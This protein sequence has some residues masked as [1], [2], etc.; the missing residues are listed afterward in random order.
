MSKPFEGFKSISA[1]ARSMGISLQTLRYRI[2]KGL[3]ART[4]RQTFNHLAESAGLNPSTVRSRLAR[5]LSLEEALSRPLPVKKNPEERRERDRPARR[6]WIERNRERRR[7]SDRKRRATPR[8]QARVKAWRERRK[9]LLEVAK[10]AGLIA[11]FA[12]ESPGQS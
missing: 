1:A 7:E 8:Y 2:A 11:T 10:D 6:K 4:G 12:T 9:K 3:P 5:G